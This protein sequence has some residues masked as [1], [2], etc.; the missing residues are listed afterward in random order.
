V[1]RLKGKTG[2]SVVLRPVYANAGIRAEYDRK[3]TALIREMARSYAWF[4]RAQYRET[5]PRM[6][7][8]RTPAQELETALRKLAQRWK[9]NFAEVAPKLARWFA[10]SN[11][12]RS[13][14]SLQKILRDAGFTVRFQITP[15]M[16]DVLAATVAE[17]VAL[18]KSIPEQFH[19][20]VQG[21]VMRSVTEGRNL[22]TLTRELQKRYGVTRRRAEFIS[23]DQNNKC[24]A[25]LRRARETEIGISEGVWLHSG[26]GRE[27]RPTHVRNSGKRFN[28]QEGW[29]DPALGGKRIWPGTEPNCRC[30][31]KP[32]VKGF[33]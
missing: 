26:G 14:K 32:V 22:S 5:P 2:K 31:W 27:P 13:D 18:I 28:L 15:A 21:M 9:R 29:P 16:N 6:A 33:S 12:S 1:A 8:D 19:I 11:L 4:L 25:M 30:T 7:I 23:R 17:N 3:L 24:T 10:R 20:Q